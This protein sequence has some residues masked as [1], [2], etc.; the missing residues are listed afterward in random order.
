MMNDCM[1]GT[2]NGGDSNAPL[3][4]RELL[5]ALDINQRSQK[6]AAKQYN[7]YDD[8]SVCRIPLM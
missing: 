6:L 3:F 2:K 8:A 4:S 1:K 5:R 7:P